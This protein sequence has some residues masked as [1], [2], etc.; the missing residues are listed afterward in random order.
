MTEKKVMRTDKYRHHRHISFIEK[1]D[2]KRDQQT[3]FSLKS[4]Q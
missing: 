3:A 2:K 4:K 1:E